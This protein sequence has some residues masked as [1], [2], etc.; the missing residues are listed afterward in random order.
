M[1]PE[2][3]LALVVI[4]FVASITPGPNNLMLLASGVNFGFRRTVPHM[5]G[6]S[7]GFFS[8]LLAVGFGLG[9]LLE[10]KPWLYLALK[11]AGGAYLIYLAAHSLR[12]RPRRGQSRG[13]AVELRRR[14]PLPMGQS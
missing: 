2:V 10:N 11:A 14:R 5:L 13:T 8:L 9:V 12:A 3:L 4:A 1:S 6:I 7:A